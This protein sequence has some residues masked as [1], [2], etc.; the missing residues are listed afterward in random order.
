LGRNDADHAKLF[1]NGLI[2]GQVNCIGIDS[3][4]A[5]RNY[6]LPKLVILI[7]A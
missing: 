5:E 7:P 4:G 1:T 2:R 6:D 3:F